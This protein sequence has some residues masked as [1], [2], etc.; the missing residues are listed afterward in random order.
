MGLKIPNYQLNIKE[1]SFTAMEVGSPLAI[2]KN[3]FTT[4]RFTLVFA[5]DSSCCLE[6]VLQEF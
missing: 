1:M 5:V 6:T 4:L 2:L 3:L